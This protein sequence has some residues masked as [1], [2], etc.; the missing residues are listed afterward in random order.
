MP[1]IIKDLKPQIKQAALDLYETI[2]Y[3]NVSMRGI[4][5]KVGIAVGTLYNYYPNKNDLFL[6]S[7]EESWSQTIDN[8]ENR[9]ESSDHSEER[10]KLLI[11]T[12][13]EDVSARKGL[14][15]ELFS[16]NDDNLSSVSHIFSRLQ[17]LIVDLIEAYHP[18]SYPERK[19]L[20]LVMVIAQL[21]HNYADEKE[22]NID[23][24]MG[25]L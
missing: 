15:K 17:T 2:G 9:I 7:L 25:I 24:L 19:A 5:K 16:N 1:K 20:T 3:D 14:G 10:L 11:T 6:S 22:K 18:N 12:L 13:Y 8:I 21:I 23:Y 4:A